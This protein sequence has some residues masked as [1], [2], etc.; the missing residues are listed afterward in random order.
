MKMNETR[1]CCAEAAVEMF[2]TIAKDY[3]LQTGRHDVP[4]ELIEMGSE[5]LLDVIEEVRR[6]SDQKKH[7]NIEQLL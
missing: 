5:I 3:Q 1:L 7:L 2:K 4:D 6:C